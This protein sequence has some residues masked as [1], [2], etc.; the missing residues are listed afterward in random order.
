MPTPDAA[1][2]AAAGGPVVLA[3]VAGLA[4]GLALWLRPWR[5]V[6]AAGPP[7]PWLALWVAL[8]GLWALDHHTGLPIVLPWSG[9]SLLVLM[10]GWPLAVLAMVAAALALPLLA[11]L[12]GADALRRLVW[13]GL[14]PATLALGLGALLRRWLPRHLFVYI[15]GRGF[16]GTLLVV[17]VAGWLSSLW[18]PGP[19]GTPWGDLMVAQGLAAFGEA[20]LSGMI[21]AIGVA[22]RPHWLATYT[23]HL[24]LPPVPR[25]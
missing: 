20:F 16:F 12:G 2:P 23:D 17:S 1:S 6:G 13:L 25:P 4:L 21:T 7:W 9:A 19:A 22:F 18:R 11:D 15:L 8:P 24:Y 3:G 14:L 5:T 10:C